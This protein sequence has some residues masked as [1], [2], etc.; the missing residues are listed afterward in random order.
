ME[1]DDK[2]NFLKEEEPNRVNLRKLTSCGVTFSV[3]EKRDDDD[4]GIGKLD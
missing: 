1:L 2:K 4:K 3:W